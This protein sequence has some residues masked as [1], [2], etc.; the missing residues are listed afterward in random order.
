[1]ADRVFFVAGSPDDLI[2]GVTVPQQMISDL[3]EISK[4]PH[5]VIEKIGSAVEG[6]RGFLDDTGL[7][8]LVKDA[9]SEKTAADA[10][11]HALRNLRPSS[12]PQTLDALEEWR[13][14]DARHVEKFSDEAFASV[15]VA[16]PQLVRPSAA[17]ERQKKAGRLRTLTGNQAKQVEIVCDARPV[18]DRE[19]TKIE[20]FVTLT[21]LKL[22]CETQA[23]DTS[24]IE[25]ML[26]PELVGELLDKA[27][28]A[29]K[30]L[31]V[32]R[33]SIH[34]WIPEGLSENASQVT[35]EN[36]S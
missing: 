3:L 8:E 30:K 7:Q 5:G 18:F 24:C 25:I 32:L 12:V 14:A 4:I 36:E 35:D 9:I 6:A 31:H 23:D 34:R 29:Q 22:V 1:M 20:G 11:V 15:R 16:L 10:V 33:E 13:H 28:K 26:S 17:L 27:A 21:T 19:R 2:R